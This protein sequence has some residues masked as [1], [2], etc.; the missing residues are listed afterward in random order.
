[1]RELHSTSR[2]QRLRCIRDRYR[3]NGSAMDA[4]QFVA[5]LRKFLQGQPYGLTSKILTKGLGRAN[6]VIGEK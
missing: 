2:R 6:L 1:H 4:R 5:Q 3:P